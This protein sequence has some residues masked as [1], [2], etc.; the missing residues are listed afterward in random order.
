MSFKNHTSKA[1]LNVFFK[2]IL[3]I[4]TA[5]SCFPNSNPDIHIYDEP[6]DLLN[7]NSSL[8]LVDL[9][10]TLNW[11]DYFLIALTVAISFV[12]I[13]VIREMKLQ[14]NNW[15]IESLMKISPYA[16]TI[17]SFMFRYN[18]FNEYKNF[19]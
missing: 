3:E 14:P 6:S 9:F 15:V 16:I 17:S 1:F 2:Y 10:D 4:N 5:R 12:S 19:D 13:W 18:I 8:N 7:E 11:I